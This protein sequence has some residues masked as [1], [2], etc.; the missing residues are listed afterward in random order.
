MT[1]RIGRTRFES[2]HELLF[3]IFHKLVVS[4]SLERFLPNW[5]NVS[6]HMLCI[7]WSYQV[8]LG[9]NWLVA[10]YLSVEI[11]P[12]C[13]HLPG[14]EERVDSNGTKIDHKMNSNVFTNNCPHYVL[15]NIRCESRCFDRLFL[16]II[17][18]RTFDLRLE[19]SPSSV[20]DR[21]RDCSFFRLERSAHQQR[22]SKSFKEFIS[23]RTM[24][25]RWMDLGTYMPYILDRKPHLQYKEERKR[26][27]KKR[28]ERKRKSGKDT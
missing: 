13:D 17:I 27:R 16:I 21:K 28:E 1:P 8:R 14:S 4:A 12:A 15:D 11:K 22:V 20:I 3:F 24:P 10:I 19:M 25:S 7:L 23:F 18:E 9:K 5:M 26:R 2:H 6:S